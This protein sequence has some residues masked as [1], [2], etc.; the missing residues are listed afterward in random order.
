MINARAETAASS[1]AFRVAFRR[2]RCIV[3]ADGFYEWQRIDERRQPYLLRRPDGELLAMAGLWSLWPD[4]ATGGWIVSAAVVTTVGDERM[5]GLHD[6]MPVL[7]ERDA[8]DAWLDPGLTDAG[9]VSL[10]IRAA[11]HVP[12]EAVAVSPLVNNVRNEGPGLVVPVEP[13]PEPEPE[14]TLFASLRSP[15]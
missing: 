15:R 9:D 2:R 3:P 13:G 8:V 7:L 5:L 12:L 4:P 1:P 14:P 11:T 10:L 6:R